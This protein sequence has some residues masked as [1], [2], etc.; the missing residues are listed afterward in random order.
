MPFT[1]NGV[2]LCVVTINEKP[3]TRAREVR[4]ELEYNKKTADIA[5][6]F[7]SQ[8]NYTQKY[9]MSDFNAVGEACGL[10]KG[11]TKIRYLHQ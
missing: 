6:A 4:R 3:W 1:F 11:F 10:A 9:Q 5:K 7:C 2:E 8:E